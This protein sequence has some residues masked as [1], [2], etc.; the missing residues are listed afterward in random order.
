M[1]FFSG[2]TTSRAA[3][4]PPLKAPQHGD[5]PQ[6]P[7]TQRTQNEPPPLNE[8][9]GSTA[10]LLW[11]QLKTLTHRYARV[12]LRDRTGMLVIALQPPF[13]A[14][15]MA[16][17][18]YD[19]ENQIWAPTYAMIFMLSLSCLW[20]GMSASVREL[21]SDQVIFRRERRV[22]VLTAPYVGSKVIVLGV[23]TALQA[24]FLAAAMYYVM[25]LTENTHFHYRLARGLCTHRIGHEPRSFHLVSLAQFRSR[26]G[27]YPLC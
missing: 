16:A 1:P 24:M 27:P 21:I 10:S 11:R 15:V 22:G 4:R 18:F 5:S 20:F 14:A 7:R 8:Q 26:S 19:G 3:G 6:S 23:L 25:P 13:L 17:V 12:K 2:L 9:S